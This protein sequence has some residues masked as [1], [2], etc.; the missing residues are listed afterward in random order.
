MLLTLLAVLV[1]GVAIFQL[2]CFSIALYEAV[3][4][5]EARHT[6]LTAGGLATALL[7]FAVEIGGVLILLL[8]R[9]LGLLPWRAPTRAQPHDRPPLIFVPGWFMNRA[10]FL[11][12]RYRLRRDGWPHAVGFNY[13]TIHG[14]IQQAARELHDVVE[15][16][17]QTTGA[18]RV[19]LIAHSMGGLVCRAYLRSFGGLER[20]ASVI[21]LGAPHQGSK[22]CAL[23]LDPMAQDM[24]PDS[25]FIED[26]AA[27][28][29]IPGAVDFTAIYA[30]FDHLV[31]PAANAYYPGVGNIVVE[32]VGHNGLLWSSRVYEL[33]RENLEY[34]SAQPA[35]GRLDEV[36][37]G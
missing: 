3:N 31:V 14:D 13:R 8:A 37:R 34:G 17:C 30:T 24:R 32:G 15:R 9:P 1:V 20:T 18:A 36:R 29:P 33:V 4:L 26:L 19:V 16:T 23:S 22:L 21:T 7:G 2:S 5:P 28:D 25:A 10:C 11:P 12:L 35:A 6:R 27:D